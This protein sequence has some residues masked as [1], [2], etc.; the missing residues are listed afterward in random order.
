MQV[1]WA[2]DEN[3]GYHWQALH[4]GHRQGDRQWLPWNDM[5]SDPA[6]AFEDS[7]A[8]VQ[9]QGQLIENKPSDSQSQDFEL[10]NHNHIYYIY[11]ILFY[12][13]LWY[14]YT[15]IIYNII[16]NYIILLVTSLLKY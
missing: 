3:K 15:T 11:V 13:I 10:L 2:D 16:L 7:D 14:I 4:C 9:A 8:E 12:M 6:K 1:G 5:L